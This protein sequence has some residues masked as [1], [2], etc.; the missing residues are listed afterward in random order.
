MEN[1]FKLIDKTGIEVI[2]PFLKKLDSSIPDIVLKTRLSEMVE[3]G[4]EC[5]GIY[6]GDELIGICGIWTLVKYYIGKHIE[7]DNVYIQPKHRNLGIGSQLNTWLKNF[8]L[9]RGCEAVE[10]N[11]YIKNEEGMRF[12]EANEY[13][14]IGMHYQKKLVVRK[15]NAE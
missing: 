4:Y 5:V 14:P 1:K 11:C 12:W 10:L 6:K 15:Y 7:P 3:N 8:A 9:S 13:L 2:L